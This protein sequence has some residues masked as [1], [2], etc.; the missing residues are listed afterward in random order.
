MKR[1]RFLALTFGLVPAATLAQQPLQPTKLAR[2]G[3]VGSGTSDSGSFVPRAVQ[4]AL[5]ERGWIEG[6]N[7]VSD[8]RFAER[9]VERLEGLVAELV[10]SKVDVIVAMQTVSAHAAKKASRGT[11]VVFATSDPKGLVENLARPEGNLTGV[12]NIGAALAGKQFQLLKEMVPGA[13][14]AAVLANPDNPSTP[15]FLQEAR[16]AAQSLGLR[17]EML[18]ARDATGIDRVLRPGAPVPTDV[19]VVQNDAIFFADAKRVVEHAAARR[20]P[21]MYGAREFPL[22]GGLASYG[23]NLLAMYRQLAGYVDPILRG[24]K[25]GDLPVTQP[26]KFE[27]VVNAKTVKMLNLTLTPSFLMR[28]DEVI[29]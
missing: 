12:T 2:V 11:P 26:A 17:L 7:I 3:Y 22:A 6:R 1:R 27:L 20:L 21:A 18:M 14:R 19:L 13:S 5:R 16:T 24:V 10:A 8:I 28:A 23:T 29:Q 25:P 9:K 4:E 15:L